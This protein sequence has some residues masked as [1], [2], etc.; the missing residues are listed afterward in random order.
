LGDKEKATAIES[1][2]DDEFFLLRL[3]VKHLQVQKYRKLH[4]YL[5]YVAAAIKCRQRRSICTIDIYQK[6]GTRQY[7]KLDRRNYQLNDLNGDRM[8]VVGIGR[9]QLLIS[10]RTLGSDTIKYLGSKIWQS[11]YSEA[12]VSSLPR[13]FSLT[14][15]R[16]VS[17][18]CGLLCSVSTVCQAADRRWLFHVNVILI[19]LQF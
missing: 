7:Q 6:Y 3:R 12:Q 8:S 15:C 18:D 10:Y 16:L 1:T 14:N 17:F 4:R 5:H 13:V 9:W 19:I 11:Q 2:M